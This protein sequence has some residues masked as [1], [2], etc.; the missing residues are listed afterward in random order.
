MRYRFTLNNATKGAFILPTDPKGWDNM[1]RTLERGLEFHG[2]TYSQTTDL[3]FFCGAGKEYLDDVYQTQGFDAIVT[4]IIERACGCIVD[5]TESNDYSI[6]YSDD[7]GSEFGGACEFEESFT[8]VVDYAPYFTTPRET[9]VKIIQTN[10]FQ[11]VRNRI[12]TK[13]DLSSTTSIDGDALTPIA[14][15]PYDVE[16]HSKIIKTESELELTEMT[17]ESINDTLNI[18]YC[19]IPFTRVA[20]EIG[21]LQNPYSPYLVVGTSPASVQEIFLNLS[22]SQ[23]TFEVFINIDFVFSIKNSEA[24]I[25]PTGNYDVKLTFVHN[26]DDITSCTSGEFLQI[27][28]T[29]I[30]TSYTNLH[31]SFSGTRTVVLDAN[32]KGFLYFRLEEAGTAGLRTFYTKI[33]TI[34]QNEISLTQQSEFL[35][36]DVKS[37]K[38]H[39][40]GAAISQRILGRDDCFRSNIF[41]RTDSAP[42]TYGSNGCGAFNILTNGKLI[43]GFPVADAPVRLSL[44]DFY[45]GLNPIYNLGMGLEKISGNYYITIDSIEHFYDD[46]VLFQLSNVPDI[47]T[48]IAPDYIYNN[49]NIGYENWQTE[50]KNGIDEFNSKRQYSTG[51]KLF[52][53]V[54]DLISQFVASGYA[55]ELTRRKQYIDTPTTDTQYDDNI[56]IVAVARSLGLMDDTEID[57]NYDSITN[58][59]NPDSSYNLRLS[60]ARSL[61]RHLKSIAGTLTKYPGRFIKFTFGEGNYKMVSDQTNGSANNTC[62]DYYNSASLAENDDIQWD[63]ANADVTPLWIPEYLEFTYPITDTQ[64]NLLRDNPYKCIEIS[65]GTS[66]YIK[67]Y[68]IRIDNNAL[69]GLTQFKLLRAYA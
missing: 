25:T 37:Y 34:T 30:G 13:I 9:S 40:V 22:D 65:D 12:D 5:Q 45:R 46:T 10:D 51:I 15:F 23:V 21:V 59:I 58:T 17:E 35:G 69:N 33:E 47:K 42:N 57:E 26:G 6:D 67:G 28:N 24:L 16:F 27:I 53:N 66:D 48:S 36:S 55:I 50:F 4:I 2:F 18:T 8:G 29:P 62:D 68:L 11:K 61:L 43:R 63:S 52:D 49:I 54:K 3:T 41:G 14:N 44:N 32:K 56:F 19:E 60:P 64:F 7:Y 38:I 1:Q 31:F 20:D 39:E